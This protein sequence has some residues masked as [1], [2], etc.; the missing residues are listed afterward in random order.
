M[1]C[2]IGVIGC[3]LDV[4]VVEGGVVVGVVDVVVVVVVV[5]GLVSV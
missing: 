3:G 5:V 2:R 4:L 1:V